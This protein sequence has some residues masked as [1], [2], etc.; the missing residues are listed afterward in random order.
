MRERERKVGVKNEG[1][2]ERKAGVKKM[3]EGKR[4]KLE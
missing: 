1:E 2:R 3:R 4:E